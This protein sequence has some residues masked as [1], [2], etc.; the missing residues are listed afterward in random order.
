MSNMQSSGW[1]SNSCSESSSISV[2]LCSGMQ[3][4]FHNADHVHLALTLQQMHK[5]CQARQSM[6]KL[7]NCRT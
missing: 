2:V 7:L 3:H 1:C 4:G 6:R 5:P